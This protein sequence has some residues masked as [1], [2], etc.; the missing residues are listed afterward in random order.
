MRRA[1]ARR[2]A[3]IDRS[4]PVPRKRFDATA[5]EALRIL[6]AARRFRCVSLCQSDNPSCN[7]PNLR[8]TAK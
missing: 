6:S 5:P 8:R 1:A 3:I 7:T 2:Q 4:S